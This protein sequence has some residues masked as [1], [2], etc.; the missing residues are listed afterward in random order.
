VEA[1]RRILLAAIGTVIAVTLVAAYVLTLPSAESHPVPSPQT[2]SADPHAEIAAQ[3]RAEHAYNSREKAFAVAK[4][5]PRAAPKPATGATRG[6]QAALFALAHECEIRKP[7]PGQ[8]ERATS[9]LL[10]EARNRPTWELFDMLLDAN[11]AAMGCGRSWSAVHVAWKLIHAAEHV[12]R[13]LPP[14]PRQR[15]REHDLE[16]ARAAA[17]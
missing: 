14:T 10:N 8:P 4:Q 2:A 1:K 7:T 11:Y 9:F 5:R 6:A 16:M 17:S 13:T 12:M 3:S 15:Q